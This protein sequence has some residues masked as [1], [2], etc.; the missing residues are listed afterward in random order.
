[1]GN[2]WNGVTLETFNRILEPMEKALEYMCYLVESADYWSPQNMHALMYI[3]VVTME[4]RNDWVVFCELAWMG[5]EPE[6]WLVAVRELYKR[7]RVEVGGNIKMPSREYAEKLEKVIQGVTTLLDVCLSFERVAMSDI[8]PFEDV[9]MRVIFSREVKAISGLNRYREV[10]PELLEAQC[11]EGAIQEQASA[12]EV[13][14]LQARISELEQALEASEA[15]R[16]EQAEQLAGM[17][18]TG[19]V[20][21][22]NAKPSYQAMLEGVL[23]IAVKYG[24]FVKGDGLYQYSVC[25]K[26]TQELLACFISDVSN[27]SMLNLQSKGGT[28]WKV[29]QLSTTGIPYTI[30]TK[31]RGDL[32]MHYTTQDTLA[33]IRKEL[34]ALK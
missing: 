30:R 14:G 34:N 1:M 12:P 3:P 9:E 13:A 28:N 17:P 11:T 22:H 4:L 20:W 5:G 29:W 2:S 21:L 19:S 24:V 32:D 8:I 25:D 10:A 23:R 7:V 16:K 31:A 27:P 26:C 6:G 15:K 18:P 33:K